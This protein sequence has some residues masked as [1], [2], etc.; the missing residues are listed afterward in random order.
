MF[1]LIIRRLFT[2]IGHRLG[3]GLW[4]RSIFSPAKSEAKL[5]VFVVQG[6]YYGE[7]SNTS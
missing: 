4:H 7:T 2:C 1:L 6:D 5:E 3:H